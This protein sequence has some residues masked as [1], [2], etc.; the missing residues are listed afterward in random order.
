[1]RITELLNKSN[2]SEFD[3][4]ILMREYY[5]AWKHK[6][7]EETEYQILLEN[8]KNREGKRP[9][10]KWFDYKNLDENLKEG[11]LRFDC[12]SWNG[13]CELTDEI[14]EI[15]WGYKRGG[16]TMNSFATTLII[17]SKFKDKDIK[18][19]RDCKEKYDTDETF[20]EDIEKTFGCYAEA[21]SSMGNFVLVPNRFNGFRGKS[22]F[23][24]DYWDKSLYYLQQTAQ[25][26]H[27]LFSLPFNK[28]VNYFFLWD[29]VLCTDNSSDYK[30]KRMFSDDFQSV[31]S[32]PL[33]NYE[34]YTPEEKEISIFL[35]NAQWAIKR[36]GIFMTTM[37]KLGVND[38]GKY[39]EQYGI[40]QDKIFTSEKCYNGYQ[41]IF[42][43]IKNMKEYKAWPQQIKDILTKAQEDIKKVDL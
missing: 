7:S 1:M 15:L 22:R 25:D 29:Y 38:N 13:T 21:V 28:Y 17:Y 4:K 19:C 41:D 27:W 43:S 35:K 36:R 40:L 23:L 18:S 20:R 42:D 3:F 9:V 10:T 26:S 16:D 32:T 11:I 30:V 6:H 14:Y 39:K 8:L 34:R 31:N 12:D 5:E 37:L 24:Q 33:D 2:P